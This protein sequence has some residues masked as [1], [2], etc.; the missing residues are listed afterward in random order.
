MISETTAFITTLP[1]IPRMITALAQWLSCMVCVLTLRRRITGWK[2][3]AAGAGFLVVQNIFLIATDGFED[4]TWNLCMLIAWVFMFLF[5]QGAPTSV[6]RRLSVTA[7]L[8][9]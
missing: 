4:I 5:I 3:A 9:L 1:D 2:F 6:N 7:V 8:L